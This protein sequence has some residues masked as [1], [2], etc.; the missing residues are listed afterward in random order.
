MASTLR[1]PLVVTMPKRCC[2]LAAFCLVPLLPAQR[3]LLDALPKAEEAYKYRHIDFGP[4]F[5]ALDLPG[6][7]RPRGMARLGDSVWIARGDELLRIEWPS[8]KLQHRVEAPPDVLGLCADGKFVY[9]L[10][11]LE[12]AV[13]DP[14]A[15]R[16]V[17]SIPLT[18]GEPPVAIAWETEG[19]LLATGGEFVRIDP[20]SGVATSAPYTRHD[21]VQ[22]LANDGHRVWAGSSRGMRRLERPDVPKSGERSWPNRQWPWKLRTSTAGWIDDKLLLLVERPKSRAEWETLGGLLSAGAMEERLSLKLYFDKDRTYYEVGPKPIRTRE[23]L[24]QELKRLADAP[25]SRF[26]G[27]DGKVHLMPV[28]IEVYPGVTV[29]ELAVAWDIAKESGFV[30]ISSP[31]Q[32]AW[33]RVEQQRAAEK[34]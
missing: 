1:V 21:D 17:R 26:A 5:Q 31:A 18:L 6:E 23:A 16:V 3:E 13:L 12:I 4:E 29:A 7:G 22:W 14:V 33:V 34:K 19:L 10:R 25:S 9:A 20:V 15:G 24:R 11:P 27:R 2:C 30:D 32:E 28:V 8:G